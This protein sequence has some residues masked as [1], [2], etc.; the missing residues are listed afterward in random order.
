[1]KSDEQL[2][3][4]DKTRCSVS[5]SLPARARLATV[6]YEAAGIKWPAAR[7]SRTVR[8]DD[9][10]E[11][12]AVR[13]RG[14]EDMVNLS[15]LLINAVIDDKPH[16]DT[17]GLGQRARRRVAPL[18]SR[19]TRTNEPLGGKAGPN[20]S[21][22]AYLEHGKPVSSLAIAASRPTVREC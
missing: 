19:G 15:E 11:S 7:L 14:W 12:H 13:E 3:C 22:G 8:G 1:V 17:V 18:D 16:G 21:T 6:G 5:G 20:S 10:G 2:S 9:D 4:T